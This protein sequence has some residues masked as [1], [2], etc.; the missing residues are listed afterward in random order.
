MTTGPRAARI[1]F[2][3][4]LATLASPGCFHSSELSGVRHELESQLPGASFD[5]DIELSLGPM[6]LSLARVVAAV[7]P[8]AGEARPWLRDLS[9]IQLG[10]YEARV[11]S[12]TDL[13]MPKHMQSLLD[14]GWET[15]IRVRDRDEAVWIL[16]RPD[17]DR[18]REVFVVVLN[19]HELVLVKAKGR[20]EK[21]IATA[22]R[23]GRTG[24]DFFS[25]FDS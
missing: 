11:D 14:D 21:L 18:V 20:L 4:A 24:R 10:V 1:A 3:F 16:Y 13:R 7:V 22:L 17:G 12:M 6:M 9:R 5:R 25:G 19:D 2:A 15:A 8:G 23:E